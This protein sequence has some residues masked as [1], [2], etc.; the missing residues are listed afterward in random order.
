LAQFAGLNFFFINPCGASDV[1]RSEGELKSKKRQRIEQSNKSQYKQTKQ[2]RAATEQTFVT[3]FDYSGRKNY[4]V[5]G[6][7]SVERF[8]V[9]QESSIRDTSRGMKSVKLRE[10][11]ITQKELEPRTKAENAFPRKKTPC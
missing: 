7:S 10:R 1:D 6:C 2:L 8:T 11:E 4:P 9:G 3:K 5:V